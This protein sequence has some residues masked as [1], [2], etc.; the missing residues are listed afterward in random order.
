[1]NE[2]NVKEYV[3]NCLINFLVSENYQN[4]LYSPNKPAMFYSMGLKLEQVLQD[5]AYG[6]IN[7]N[8]L[9]AQ[10]KALGY[11]PFRDMRSWIQDNNK[12]TVIDLKTKSIYT[13]DL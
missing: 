3:R 11:A 10:L 5:W 12:A 9:K 4:S 8:Q 7:N 2:Q 6:K 1:M 13:I